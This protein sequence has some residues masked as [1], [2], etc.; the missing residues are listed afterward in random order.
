MQ[1]LAQFVWLINRRVTQ[2]YTNTVLYES[3]QILSITKTLVQFFIVV[4]RK[5][6]VSNDAIPP[7]S[8]LIGMGF[9][10]L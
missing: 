6:C 1:T 8:C 4:L 2:F 9:T 5:C 7:D 3:D 10:W